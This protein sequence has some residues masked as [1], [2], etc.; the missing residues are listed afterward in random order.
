[1]NGDMVEISTDVAI[2][3]AGPVGM[4]GVFQLGM[5]GIN[6]CLIDNLQFVGGQ[7]NALYPE[8]PIYDIPGFPKIVASELISQLNEQMMPFKP[9]LLLGNTA[10]ALN[11]EYGDFTLITDCG[12]KVKCKAV[13]ICA[14]SGSF[15]PNR[16][17]IQDI[18]KYESKSVFY[19]VTQKNIFK[20]KKVAI[21]GGGDSAADW[22]VILSDIAEKVYLIHRRDNFRC[23]PQTAEKISTIAKSGKIEMCIPYQM[24]AITGDEKTIEQLTL[25][26]VNDD[27]R[28]T[29]D[30]DLILPFFGLNTDVS[31][32]DSFNIT[33]EKKHI[34]VNYANMQSSRAGIF[35]AGDIATYNGKL[36]LILTGFAEVAVAAHSAYAVVFPDKPLH[37]QHSTTKGVSNI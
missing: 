2:I 29:I 9:Q 28:K 7:C 3:G 6:S 19:S 18:E 13:I 8:K 35:A 14:G 30:V 20:D 11:G 31:A 37:F 15:V 32:L 22:A 34:V 10:V 1:M 17:A 33:I 21:A 4:F 26:N 24:H 23:L 36:K 25:L 16:P 5:L 12:N 27:S